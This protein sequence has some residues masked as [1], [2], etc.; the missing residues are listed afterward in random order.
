MQLKAFGYAE[1]SDDKEQDDDKTRL[2]QAFTP[3]RPKPGRESESERDLDH[4]AALPN[5]R[6][7]NPHALCYRSLT[8]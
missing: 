8:L 7:Q 5:E 2:S 1:I 6:H 3:A 4:V